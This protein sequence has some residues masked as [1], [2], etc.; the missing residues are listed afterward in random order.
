MPVG[1]IQHS[2]D[3]AKDGDLTSTVGYLRNI[4]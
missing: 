3:Q 2:K 4:W 1:Q